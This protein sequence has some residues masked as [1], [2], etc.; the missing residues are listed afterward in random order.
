MIRLFFI[1]SFATSAP[2]EMTK[3]LIGKSKQYMAVGFYY[4][5]LL[6]FHYRAV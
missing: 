3:S 2:T 6:Q 5:I 1:C 4:L